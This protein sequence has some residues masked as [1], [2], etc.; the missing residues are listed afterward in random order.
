M[1]FNSYSLFIYFVCVN[2][3]NN[4]GCMT[5]HEYFVVLKKL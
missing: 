3:Y 2:I 4:T 5:C 1:S